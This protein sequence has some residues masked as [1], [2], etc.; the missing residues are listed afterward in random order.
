MAKDKNKF[1]LFEKVIFILG[2]FLIGLLVVVIFLKIFSSFL[3]VVV[4]L[5]IDA[6]GAYY[7]FK[8]K[9]Q[10]IEKKYIAYGIISAIILTLLIGIVLWGLISALF[11]GIAN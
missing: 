9:A 11:Q 2:G 4:G 6:G 10:Q 5:L 1:G 8:K 7:I 3:G